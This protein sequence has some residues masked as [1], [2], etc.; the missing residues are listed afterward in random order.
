LHQ[1]P[2]VRE[3]WQNNGWQPP[4]KT[5]HDFKADQPPEP[6]GFLWGKLWQKA[7]SITG[8]STD[9]Y[10]SRKQNGKCQSG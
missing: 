7:T 10:K 4:E 5:D 9:P 1:A 8:G 3:H 6:A 2:C